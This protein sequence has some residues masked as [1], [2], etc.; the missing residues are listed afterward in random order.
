MTTTQQPIAPD[1]PPPSLQGLEHTGEPSAMSD[2]FARNLLESL[3]RFRDGDFASRMPAE[4]SVTSGYPSST[5]STFAARSELR[6][7][8]SGP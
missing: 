4:C 1:S 5:V 6:L 8:E 3:V 2:A 7:Q